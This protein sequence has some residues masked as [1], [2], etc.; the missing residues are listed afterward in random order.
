VF[1][2]TPETIAYIQTHVSIGQYTYTLDT[3][4]TDF[5]RERGLSYRQK[6][7][8]YT[9]MLFVFEKPGVYQFWMKDM[10]FPIDI[11]WL[12]TDKKVVY[13]EHSLSPETYPHAFGPHTPVRWVVE[14]PAG[15]VEQGSLSVG[16][17]LSF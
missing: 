3:A 16:D 5:L 1:K 4:D 17:I 6:I 15:A 10:N 2:K 7:D 11:V 8:P 13:I 9:G 12:D 14:L